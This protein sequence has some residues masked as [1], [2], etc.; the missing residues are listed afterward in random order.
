VS[1]QLCAG[2]AAAHEKGVLHRD[3]KP[4]NVIIDAQ[5]KVRIT[6]FGLAVLADEHDTD[7]ARAGTPAYM[8]PEQLARNEVSVQSDLYSLGVVLYEMFTGRRAFQGNSLLEVQRMHEESAPPSPSTILTDLDPV[9][10]RAILRC[11]EKDPRNR[12]PSAL[13]VAAGLPG[14]DPLAAALAAGEL[15]SPEIVAAAGGE[16]ALRPAVAWGLLGIRRGSA[17]RRCE[18][19]GKSAPRAAG[20]ARQAASSSGR[21]RRG[22]P[23]PGAAQRAACRSGQG[24]RRRKRL[25]RL[26]RQAR[27]ITEPLASTCSVAGRRRSVSGTGRAHAN[28]GARGLDTLRSRSPIRRRT[29]PVKPLVTLD[30]Q[31]R[32]LQLDMEAAQR[33]TT[34]DPGT[35]PDWNP[36]FAAAGLDPARFTPVTPQWTPAGYCDTRAAWTGTDAENPSLPLRV[37]VG[38]YHG[39]PSFFAL[40][41][42]WSR[43]TR[44]LEQP[45]SRS[46]RFTQAFLAVLLLTLLVGSVQQ[47]RRN[48]Q[49][50]HADT[51]GA[52]RLAIY[53]LVT[54]S[55]AWVL[56]ENHSSSFFAEYQLFN[57]FLGLVL[58]ISGL[59]WVLYVA[60]EPLVRRRWPDS[61]IGWSR[62]IGGGWRDP[63][64]GRDVLIGLALAA[65]TMLLAELNI[66]LPQS[67]GAPP[68]K[69]L[70]IGF[71]SLEG[72]QIAI[73]ELLIELT[74]SIFLPMALV[75][76]FSVLRGLLRR[77][78]LAAVVMLALFVPVFGAGGDN[79]WIDFPLAA[80]RFGMILFVLVRYGLLAVASGTFAAS[81]LASF[82]AMGDTSKW[83]APMS[84]F[85]G[86]ASWP[87]AVRLPYCDRHPPASQGAA[88]SGNLIGSV[89]S[90]E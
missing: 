79:P 31:G 2:V 45:R 11:L 39:R 50:K 89:D 20:T 53:V 60:L 38:S 17:H 47:A 28:C 19:G 55:L 82:V 14:G 10:E 66:V 48:I 32:L 85:A 43:P 59:M 23:A 57:S 63:R 76:L 87:V 5:G 18:L 33:D 9:I 78:W 62:L 86:L 30:P 75:F 15:P 46:E 83:F 71:A 84:I 27:Q 29:S 13:A 42:E 51:R 54:M 34:E 21:A 52:W 8:A 4:A 25:P 58:F 70:D 35:V 3:L 72:V 64:V 77:Q 40:I 68:P 88:A 12:P 69:L 81:L 1:R 56:A 36:L 16:G 37:E 90:Q 22:H 80:L 41:G 74:N 65:C 7:H 24:F 26:G 61:L 6:D 44:M 73:A 67:F 49:R